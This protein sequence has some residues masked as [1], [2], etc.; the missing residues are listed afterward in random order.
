MAARSEF[1]A[2]GDEDSRR[3]A[4]SRP[5]AGG[6]YPVI[7]DKLPAIIYVADAGDLG[8]WHYVSPQIEAIL[9]YTPEQ[10]CADPQMWLKRLHPE[11][12]DRVLSH[13]RDSVVGHT[14]TTALEYRLH[15]RDGHIVWIRD[16]AKL[17][18]DVSG[19][20]HWH[21]VLSDITE[22]KKA[23]A[24]LERRAAQ[25]SAVAR[26]GEH[27]LEGATTA[28]LMQEA[29]TVAAEILGV[30]TTAVLELVEEIDGFVMRAGV[31]WPDT[32]IDAY[33]APTG[34]ASHA[35]YT[36]VK[37]APV[38]V[39]DWSQETRFKQS[40]MLASRG[41]LSGVTV[42]IV[43]SGGPYGILGAQSLHLRQYSPGDVDFLQS[44]ANVLADALERQATEDRIRHSALHDPLTGLPN[45]VLFLDRLDQ[46]L[47]RLRRRESLCAI[48]FLDLDHFKLVNDSL[49]HQVGDDLLA[50]AAP[51]IKQAVRM[52]DTVARFGGDEFGILL[53]DIS[54]EHEAS[55]MAERIA[56]V[57]TRPFVLAGSEHFV[58]TSIGIALARGGEVAEELIRDADAAMYRAKEHGRARYELFDE[59]MR[60]RA[61]ARLRVENDLRRA[62]ERNELVLDFQPVVSLREHSIVSLEALLRW[63]HPERGIVPPAEFIPIAEENGLIEPI[64]RWVLEEACRQASVWHRDRPDVAPVTISVNLSAIQV[65]KRGLADTVAEVLR[66]TR[67]DPGALSLEITESVMLRDAD[68][69]KDTLRALKA[70]GVRLVLDD[71]GTGYASL[72]YL[73]RLPLDTLKVDRSFVDGLGTE[74]RDTAITEA[75][76]AMSRA[77]SLEVIGEGVET[78]LQEA[79]LTRLGCQF[80]QGFYFSRPVSAPEITLMLD[81]GPSWTALRAPAD[82]DQR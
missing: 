11:D 46:A 54:G 16:D 31:G 47:A 39:N 21:G 69:L 63:R 56:S 64:G 75:I 14:D 7:L 53:E 6:E 32:A 5:A 50:E 60:G 2:A 52:S 1:S 29:V 72:G 19:A 12:R 77:L 41:A 20:L 79:E 59:V 38:I 22:R 62:L 51:R 9:G 81:R 57:F 3:G 73:T 55:Q 25:Q 42:P 43:G 30:E 74:P 68:A 61:M 66:A 40:A 17:V 36:L 45:R 23:E 71:F 35:G 76:V 67:L 70:L 13:E 82:G 15:H 8:R 27:A 58:T 24:E 26:L 18:H 78:P 10:W 65:A 49:G 4:T 80:A 44:L 37:R 33:H 28:E 34:I 48:L